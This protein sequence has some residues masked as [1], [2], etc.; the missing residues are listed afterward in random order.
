MSSTSLAVRPSDPSRPQGATRTGRALTVVIVTYN[1]V[2]VIG[3]CLASVC[4]DLLPA[5][6]A[7]DAEVIVVDNASADG[8]AALV[9]DAFPAVRLIHSPGNVG[10]AAAINAGIVAAPPTGA[11]LV[12]NPDIRLAPGAVDALRHAPCGRIGVTVPRLL[13]PDGIVS[14]SIRREPGVGRALADALLGGPRAARLRLGETVTEPAAYAHFHEVEWASGA[15]LL[16]TRDCLDDVG[17]FDES[18]F[19]Y[20][21]ET[22]FMLRARDAGWRVAFVPSATVVH[23]GGEMSTSA[24][25]WSMRTLNRVR[26]QRRRH[27][28]VSTALFLAVSMLGEGGRAATG[29]DVSRRAVLDLCRRGPAVV[30]GGP[31]PRVPRSWNPPL[32]DT[33]HGPR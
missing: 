13:D 27:G 21:E 32:S 6:V 31:P 12:L 28:R 24:P 7:G 4:A 22:D 1:S 15:A 10:Y 23:R 5:I 3:P 19:L 2:G 14:S 20:S 16:I 11:V 29:R 8:T 9:A 33:V 26:L 17:P 30:A 25:L 18:F